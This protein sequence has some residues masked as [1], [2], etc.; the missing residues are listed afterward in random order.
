MSAPGPVPVQCVGLAARVLPAGATRDRYR[1]EF[2]AELYVMTPQQ[3]R[4]FAL[5]VL[6][7]AWSL[8]AAVMASPLTQKEKTMSHKA[9]MCRLNLHHDWHWNQTEDGSRYQRCA[10]C[11]KDKSDS[12]DDGGPSLIGRGTV[13]PM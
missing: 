3:R 4:R 1:R 10:K 2:V 12:H 9:L 8:R 11:G 7:H 6:T 13:I 5:G